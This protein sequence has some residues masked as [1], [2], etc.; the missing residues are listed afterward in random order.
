[1]LIFL[2]KEELQKM[3]EIL[4]ILKGVQN[5]LNFMQVQIGSGAGTV[6]PSSATPADMSNKITGGASIDPKQLQSIERRLDDLTEQIG[7]TNENMNTFVEQVSKLSAAKI[8]QADERINQATRLLEKGLAL[9]EMGAQLT[10]IK[11]RMEEI[12]VE[13]ASAAKQVNNPM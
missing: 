6:H 8:E 11:D 13:L 7:R 12:L 2:P 9:T 3:N 10:E 1:M 4:D 5:Q